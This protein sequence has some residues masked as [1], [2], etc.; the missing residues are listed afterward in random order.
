MKEVFV[1]DTHTR[2]ALA[3]VRELGQAGYDVVSVTQEGQPS[4]GHAS[5]YAKRRVTLS[6]DDIDYTDALLGLVEK[7][8]TD[9]NHPVL[10]PAGS[11]T[12]NLAAK[13]RNEFT[14]VFNMLLPE[15]G[16]LQAAGDKPTVAEAARSL[17]LPVPVEYTPDKPQFPCVIKYRNGEALGI[18]AAARY[19]II[20][21]EALYLDTLNR[22]KQHG[23][24]FVSEYIAGP[25]C[26]VSA[27]LDRDSNTLAVF[28]HKRIRE[29]PPSGGPSCCA[30]SMWDGNLAEAGLALLKKLN[31]QGF[32]MVEFKG[33]HVLEVNP[34]I[35]GTYPLSRICGAGMATA[36]AEGA[37][38]NESNPTHPYRRGVRMQYLPND[39]VHFAVNLRRGRFAGG[40]LSDMFSPRV[41]GGVWDWNDLSGTWAY[42]KMLARGR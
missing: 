20:K 16:N 38:L 19:A 40:V 37:S 17:G 13:R 15:W 26:G 33:G 35:W 25:A 24:V 28:C 9:K 34:R 27:V 22:M 21:N 29:Y 42:M 18:K 6:G 5:R 7:S 36:Y 31:V 30:E 14:A 11:H 8:S 41:K 23:E 10:L 39:L 2:M 3:V 12:L 1:T 4:L 32:A